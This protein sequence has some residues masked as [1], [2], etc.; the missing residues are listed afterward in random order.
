MNEH[1]LAIR[2]AAY[3]AG[4]LIAAL[5]WIVRWRRQRRCP[6]DQLAMTQNGRRA[7]C[8]GCFKAGSGQSMLEEF[9]QRQRARSGR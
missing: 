1:A 8:L 2:I 5:P 3:V 6:H 9:D 7:L 4:A